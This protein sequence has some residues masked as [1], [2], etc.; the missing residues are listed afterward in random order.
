MADKRLI[1]GCTVFI[2]VMSFG[3]GALLAYVLMLP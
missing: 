3:C 2:A 1:C